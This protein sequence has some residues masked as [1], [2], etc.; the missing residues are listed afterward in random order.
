MDAESLNMRIGLGATRWAKGI[1]TSSLDGIG[2]YTHELCVHL[3]RLHEQLKIIPVVFGSTHLEELD[4]A[5]IAR[6]PP[7]SA[8]AL[9]SG[10]TPKRW[11]SAINSSRL[12][13][14]FMPPIE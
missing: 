14:C 4:G 5:S 7:Y 1:E 6:V 3:Q 10:V 11:P 8:S 9:A 12:M 2:H 13:V